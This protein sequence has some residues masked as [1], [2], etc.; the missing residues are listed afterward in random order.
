MFNKK[1][2]ISTILTCVA[3][4]CLSTNAS[5]SVAGPYLG[6]QAGAGNVNQDVFGNNSNYN[7]AGR[8][9]AGYAFN[10][11]LALE[12]GFTKYSDVNGSTYIY[13]VGQVS[14]TIK[15]YTAD[16][17]GKL[18]LPLQNG[19]SIYGKLGG[20]YVNEEAT[21][22]ISSFGSDSTTE[23]KIFPEA[24]VGVSYDIN[25]NLVADISW[26]HI[27]KVGSNDLGNLDF[28]AVGLTYHFG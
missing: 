14:G 11:Y 16:I 9:Y 26:T 18:T 21:A 19:F 6:A 1:I 25:Q 27:Q 28:G 12:T 4:I 17:A 23:H 5:A 7:L 20:A 3:G 22:T 2:M 8:L 13:F 24:G 10:R 15:T